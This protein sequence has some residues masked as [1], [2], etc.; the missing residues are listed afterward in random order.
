MGRSGGGLI[1]QR[2]FLGH[3]NEAVSRAAA[4]GPAGSSP[5]PWTVDLATLATLATLAPRCH[6]QPH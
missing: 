2:G 6:L 5:G 4:G 1:A 3:I